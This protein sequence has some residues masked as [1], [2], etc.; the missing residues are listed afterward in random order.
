M[1]A[2]PSYFD[3]LASLD[4][5]QFGSG[6]LSKTTGD[7]LLTRQTECP[8]YIGSSE[9]GL[10][11]LLELDDPV[12]DWQYFRFHPWSGVDMRPAGNDESIR[13]LFVVRSGKSIPGVQPVFELFPE[14]EEWPTRELYKQHPNVPDQWRFIGRA[15][16]VIVL[17][18]GEKINP[19]ETESRISNNH[20]AIS[21]ALVIGSGRFMPGLL[22]ETRDIDT[23]DPKERFQLIEEIWPIVER[24]NLE[25]PKHGQLVKSLILFTSPGKPFARTPKLSVRRGPTIDSYATEIDEI[26]H[27]Y[28]TDLE[29]V[30]EVEFPLNVVVA[31]LRDIQENLMSLIQKLTGW[32]G[33]LD[34]GD[35]VFALG[36]DSLHVARI[37]RALKQLFSRAGNSEI[38]EGITSQLVYNNPTVNALS[39]H[40]YDLAFTGSGSVGH[41]NE[42]SREQEIEAL[43]SAQTKFGFDPS[44]CGRKSR[45]SERRALKIVLTGSTGSLGSHILSTLLEN[46]LVGNIY[47]LNRAKDAR[48]RQTA[49]LASHG[50]SGS[51]RISFDTRVHF[52]HVDSLAA[53]FL[54]LA[55]E[56]TYAQIKDAGV[57]HIIHNAWPVNFNLSLASFSSHVA[58]VRSLVD[59]CASVSGQQPRL[60]FVSSLSSVTSLS[61]RSR[62]PEEIVFDA[63]APSHMGYGESKYVAERILHEASVKSEG[64]ITGTVLRVG[65]IA[66]PVDR[67]TAVW[68]TREW[69]PS[70]V[71]SSKTIGAL[72]ETLGRMERVDWIPVDVLADVIAELVVR[73]ENNEKTMGERKISNPATEVYHLLNPKPASW[74]DE[75]LPTV[76]MQIGVDVA[77]PLVEW[78]DRVSIGPD[79]ANEERPNPAKKILDFYRALV[80][81]TETTYEAPVDAAK[82]FESQGGVREET[83][84][85][86][87]Y[88]TINAGRHSKKFREMGP[89]TKEWIAKWTEKWFET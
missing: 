5:V 10:Y 80:V 57:T 36:L 66:G 7:T 40:L 65:Q 39:Q 53:P 4:F 86:G 72:P 81:P 18:N 43:I 79:A 47:C 69:L 64:A 76:Q 82:H 84:A 71:I 3:T 13:E 27:R 24:A 41:N 22:L 6:P 1:I 77:L 16:D 87:R 35:D 14:L 30:A 60:L 29:D 37:V 42:T 46:P 52:L 61:M 62:V 54:G 85:P 49:L 75:L 23:R 20:P 59:F 31:S 58:G 89:V 32:D 33:Q 70:L 63:S 68:P 50:L 34:P 83:W 48:E 17:S 38:Q 19:I 78:I 88:D 51:A 44:F 26:Y 8:H 56:D 25:A 67:S 21:G 74:H 9:C 15:D 55:D 2:V 11:I 45:Q 73:N 28:E 12:R